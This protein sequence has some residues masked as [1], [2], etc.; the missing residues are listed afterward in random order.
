MERD[1][2]I[3]PSLYGVDLIY[4]H[5][6]W[7]GESIPKVLHVVNRMIKSEGFS[8]SLLY[9]QFEWESH[10]WWG[11]G[12]VD[13]G[14]EITNKVTNPRVSVFVSQNKCNYQRRHSPWLF[15]WHSPGEPWP[16]LLTFDWTLYFTCV[17]R[18]EWKAHSLLHGRALGWM[19]REWER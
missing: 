13:G 14:S 3:I 7:N 9:H 12:G 18:W 17:Q 15:T 6:Y 4:K 8:L 1:W 10:R 11:T 19:K 2:V 5:N 16:P